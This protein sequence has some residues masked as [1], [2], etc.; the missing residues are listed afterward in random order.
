MT[1]HTRDQA[2]DP[3][4][5]D[6]RADG[7]ISNTWA[8][9]ASSRITL[10]GL[11]PLQSVLAGPTLIPFRNVASVTNRHLGR[12]LVCTLKKYLCA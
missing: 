1:E 8:H 3:D 12:Y 10:E 4:T 6:A 9:S 11:T 2:S 7:G 5:Y